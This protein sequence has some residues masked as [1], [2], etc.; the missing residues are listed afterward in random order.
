M[1]INLSS[2]TPNLNSGTN[3]FTGTNKFKNSLTQE[4]TSN[5]AQCIN[6]FVSELLTLGTGAATTDT[7][8]DLPVN[9]VIKSV[10]G[11]VT[12][13]ITTASTFDVG[14]PTTAQRFA[15]GVSGALST[16]FVGLNH[17]KGAVSTDAAGPTQITTA[18]V[19]VTCNTTPGAGVVRITIFY[20]QFVAPTS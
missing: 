11:R 2:Q 8:M 7:S 13:A 20:E 9:S 12:T 14:D 17:R 16:T 18:K 4:T 15:T 19:R 1:P 3:T 5:A 6:G 10:V